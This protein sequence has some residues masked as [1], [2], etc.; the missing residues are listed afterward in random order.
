MNSTP[1]KS[2]FQIS[3]KATP[4]TEDALTEALSSLFGQP[5]SSYTDAQTGTCTIMVHLDPG[6]AG[7][8]GLDAKSLSKKTRA[9]LGDLRNAGLPVGAGHVSVKR[10]RKEDWAESWKRHFHPLD[11]EGKLLVKPDWSRRKP[12]KNQALV[13]LNPGLSFGTGQH[14]TTSFCLRQIVVCRQ[15][16]RP[17]S[18]LDAGTGSGILAIAAVKLGY[19]PVKAFDY[20]PESIRVAAENATANSVLDRIDLGRADV[21]RIPLRTRE[22]YDVVCTNLLTNLLIAEL[23]RLMARLAPGGRLVLAG[24]LR[25]EFHE[26][27]QACENAGL[28]LVASRAEKEWRSGAFVRR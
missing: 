20:D 11:I 3:V 13:V 15:P 19:S 10:L 12:R 4:E 9:V 25:R 18:L 6:A 23:P 26:V 21:T 8:D 28:K 24:I 22:R 27:R 5:A 1:S 7:R 14:P 2:I 16:G 17:Q